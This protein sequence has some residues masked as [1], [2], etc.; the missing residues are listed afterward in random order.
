[1]TGQWSDYAVRTTESGDSASW[2]VGEIF[3]AGAAANQ[4]VTPTSAVFT[5]TATSPGAIRSILTSSAVVTWVAG[6][7]GAIRSVTTSAAVVTWVA[8]TPDALFPGHVTTTPAVVT[9][10]A[11]TPGAIRSIST[12]SAVVTWVASTPTGSYAGS[13]STTPAVFNW[14][15]GTP[16]A[17]LI[18]VVW[19]ECCNTCDVP[20]TETSEG[21]QGE[22]GADGAA[23]ADGYNAYTT[24]S[25]Y[26][27]NPQPVVPA[28]GSSVTV[29]VADSRWIQYR[30]LV[31]LSSVGY[32]QV[33]GVPSQTSVTLT[34]V[35]NASGAYG[36]NAVPGTSITSGTL[37][38]PGG[39]QGP[40]RHIGASL[41]YGNGSPEGAVEATVGSLYTDVDT[42]NLWKKVAG[43]GTIGWA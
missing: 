16:L 34:N 14:V 30:Q 26:L 22:A 33:A 11:G 6:T 9:W 5:L 23:G 17:I 42:G 10:V 7:P 32:F 38:S 12:T 3:S 29:N 25:S 35:E 1:M 28:M 18:P 2:G 15:A 13:V 31:F 24:V 19:S 40:D 41:Y 39:V 8:S 20:T 43:T 37:V 27:P 36:T 4:T 21:P